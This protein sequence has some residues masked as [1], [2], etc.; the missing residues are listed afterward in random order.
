MTPSDT[1]VAGALDVDARLAVT[2]QQGRA[3]ILQYA[4]PELAGTSYP[5]VFAPRLSAVVRQG[6][7]VWTATA[8]DINGLGCG[9][10]WEE[11]LED[12]RESVEEYL[13]YIRDDRP[14]LAPDIAHHVSFLELLKTPPALWF[15]S[16][17]VYA[18]ALE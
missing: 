18:T 6:E 7:A 15:A 10:T 3:M 8:P 5:I 13:E 14:E 4:R 9:D 16:V 11:A 17:S 1:L 2:P 12:L